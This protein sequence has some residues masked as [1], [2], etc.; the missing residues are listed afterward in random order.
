MPLAWRAL[1]PFGILLATL[2]LTRSFRGQRTAG[3]VGAAGTGVAGLLALGELLRLAPGARLDLLYASTF[4]G[5]DLAIRL[6]GLSLSF[7]VVLLATASALMLVRAQVPTNT[8]RRDPWSGW[9][10]TTAAALAVVLSGNLLLAYIALQLLTLAWSGA[11]DEAVPRGRALRVV[12]AAAD[13][14]LLLAAAGAVQSVGTSAFAGLPPD[15]LGGASLGLAIL[16]GVARL[17]SLAFGT[18]RPRATVIYEPAIAWAAPGVYLLLRVFSLTGGQ[19]AARPAQVALFGFALAAAVVS[20]LLALRANSWS[21]IAGSLLAVQAAFA[22]ALAAVGTPIMVIAGTWIGLQLIPLTGLC[23]VQHEDGSVGQ[24]AATINLALI[25]PSLAFVGVWLGF[26]GLAQGRV[27]LVAIPLAVLVV[28]TVL[29]AG[30][31]L[32]LRPVAHLNVATGWVAALM[33]TAMFPAPLVASFVLPAARS[34]RNI[35]DGTLGTSLLGLQAGSSFWPSAFVVFVATGLL[36]LATLSRAG[37]VPRNSRR[38]PIIRMRSNL[39]VG[40]RWRLQAVRGV[41]WMALSWGIYLLLAG[42]VMVR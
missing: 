38:F 31:W 22:V 16:P 8:D 15:A 34:I 20:C 37:W 30:S 26:Q 17:G 4:P 9:L 32:V 36:V 11:L 2:A 12:H 33:L 1:L 19:P 21:R 23:S 6:D 14:G 13:L 41:P 24:A 18:S 3:Y 29:I 40:A 42:A 39:D 27:V 35:P 28:A 10:V 7:A 25:P 5:A